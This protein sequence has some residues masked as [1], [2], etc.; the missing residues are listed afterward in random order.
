MAATLGSTQVSAHV[1][2]GGDNDY[3][4]VYVQNGRSL[5]VTVRFTHSAG[6]L[7]VELLSS[8][9][10]R[11][12]SSESTSDVETVSGS[13]LVAGYYYVRVFGYD[14]AS[15]SYTISASVN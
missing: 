3:Y 2:S 5:S 13:N 4:K 12:S 6:D 7:D 14:G 9:G 15:N 8:S 10:Q 1:C 11:V